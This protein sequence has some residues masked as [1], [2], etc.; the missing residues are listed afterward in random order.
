[1]CVCA[2]ARMRTFLILMCVIH[3]LP[4]PCLSPEFVHFHHTLCVAFIL[5]LAARRVLNSYC[6]QS[7]S[8]GLKE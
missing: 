1:M 8:N 4:F 3:F 7:T 2:R 6:L 5:M